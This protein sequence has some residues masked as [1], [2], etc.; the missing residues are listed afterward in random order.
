[1]DTNTEF[2]K[3]GKIGL[4]VLALM[5]VAFIAGEAESDWRSQVVDFVE[6]PAAPLDTQLLI[7][8]GQPVSGD[9]VSGAI[10]ELS[11]VPLNVDGHIDLG[12]SP[13]DVVIEEYR[14]S[15]F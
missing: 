11:V 8:M 5:A 1:M 7:D 14:R 13:D 12:W 9:E 15:G 4:G 6:R 2:G 10:R 3:D